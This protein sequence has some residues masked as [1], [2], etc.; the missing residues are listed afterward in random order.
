LKITSDEAEDGNGDGSTLND[1]VIAGDCKSAQLR[2]ERSVSGNGRVYVITFKV[3]D[4]AGNFTTSTA[5]VTVRSS[6]SIPAVEDAP[7]YTVNSS[8]P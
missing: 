1:I 4:S 5:R 7:M 3:Q 2:A 6:P 8:C